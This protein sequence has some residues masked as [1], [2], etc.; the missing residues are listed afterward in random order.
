MWRYF[1]IVYTTYLTSQDTI[2]SASR[3]NI[4]YVNKVEVHQTDTVQLFHDNNSR[5]E[6]EREY[7]LMKMIGVT[8]GDLEAIKID[9]VKVK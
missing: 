9:S 7:E 1:I 6:A 8:V 2:P 4:Y 3:S 5:L